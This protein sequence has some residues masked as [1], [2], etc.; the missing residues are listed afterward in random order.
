[1]DLIK[2]PDVEIKTDESEESSRAVMVL[3][4]RAPSPEFLKSLALHGELWAVD[5]GVDACRAA[6]LVPCVVVGDRDSGSAQGWRW[7][8]E[9]GA[10]TR[11]Y[12]SDKDLT[13]F[14]LA[15]DIF[16]NESYGDKKIILTGAFGG[17]FDHLWS[18]V[19]SFISM[20]R[21]ALCVAD[22]AEGMIFL[23]SGES[24]ALSFA[25]RPK[26]LSLL[27]FSPR[28]TGVNIRGVRWTLSDA[29]LRFDF[30]YSVSNRIEGDGRVEVSCGD[31]LL[32]LYW[33]WGDA[34]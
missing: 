13:D 3:G 15:L 5:R 16:A 1:M 32:A 25:R 23:R 12:Q 31:G 34:F 21:G 11:E 2:L 18:L 27:S 8:A 6:G 30:P 7:A 22:D 20:T 33:T 26:A 14:Q 4:G 24:R 9:H 28:C 19:I 10:K 29:E 17:R